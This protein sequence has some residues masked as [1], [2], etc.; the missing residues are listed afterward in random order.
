MIR[1]PVLAAVAIAA[2]TPAAAQVRWTVDKAASSVGFRGSM[3]G[4]AFDGRFRRWDAQIL[5]DPAALNKSSVTAVIDLASAATGDASRDQ[6][7]PGGEWFDTARFPRA[8][9]TA[10]KFQALGGTRYAAIGTLTIRGVSRPV[11][12]PFQLVIQGRQARM[13]GILTLNRTTFGIGQ[14]QFAGPDTVAHAVQVSVTI[15]ATR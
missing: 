4:A 10:K 15:N 11:T 13:R 1:F 8:T 2:A 6:S 3:S 14:G 5:F 9:F 12:L 7:L